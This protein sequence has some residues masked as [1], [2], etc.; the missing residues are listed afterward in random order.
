MPVNV[1]RLGCPAPAATDQRRA[2]CPGFP[3]DLG[4][5]STRM[6]GG[7]KKG[8]GAPRSCAKAQSPSRAT[9]HLTSSRRERSY[10]GRGNTKGKLRCLVIF[11]RH[12]T[13]RTPAP[14]RAVKDRRPSTLPG[15]GSAFAISVTCN[16]R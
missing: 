10:V 4:L 1:V 8:L 9:K 5:T 15:G 3:E 16:C 6:V 11:Y 7:T 2:K 14:V 12:Y 13:A